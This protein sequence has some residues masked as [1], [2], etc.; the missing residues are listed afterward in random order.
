MMIICHSKKPYKWD[1]QVPGS[2]FGQD[3]T[4]WMPIPDSPDVFN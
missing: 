1:V 2:Y 4:H 3:V